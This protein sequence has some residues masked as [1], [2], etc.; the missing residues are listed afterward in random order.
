M[1]VMNQK[2][3]FCGF[4]KHPLLFHKGYDILPLK[5]LKKSCL[6]FSDFLKMTINYNV[7][8]IAKRV[9]FSFSLPVREEKESGRVLILKMSVHTFTCL[10]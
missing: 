4:K 5:T 6:I 10:Y 3:D 2:Y 1:Y 7:A 9:N 8:S